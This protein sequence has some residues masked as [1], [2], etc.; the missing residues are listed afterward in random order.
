MLDGY[1]GYRM[2]HSLITEGLFPFSFSNDRVSFSTRTF[3]AVWLSFKLN[4]IKT[5]TRMVSATSIFK[6][7]FPLVLFSVYFRIETEN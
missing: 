6:V 1:L 5:E 3:S 4:L 7:V 2:R